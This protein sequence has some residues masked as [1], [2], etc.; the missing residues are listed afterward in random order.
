MAAAAVYPNV[1]VI[2]TKFVEYNMTT[3]LGYQKNIPTTLGH[4]VVLG[5]SFFFFA[6]REGSSNLNNTTRNWKAFQVAHALE[7][8]FSLHA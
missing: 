2:Q 1:H 7:C 4:K 8:M 6:R 5:H 3:L